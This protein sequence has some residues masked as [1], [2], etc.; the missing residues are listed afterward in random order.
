MEYLVE[1][2]KEENSNLDKNAK[3]VVAKAMK[4][5]IQEWDIQVWGL[6][7]YNNV[8]PTGKIFYRKTIGIEKTLYKQNFRWVSEVKTRKCSLSVLIDIYCVKFCI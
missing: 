7:V 1:I 4:D 8:V 2:T 6:N 5:Y 3:R